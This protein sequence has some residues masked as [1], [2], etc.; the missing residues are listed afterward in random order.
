MRHL[1]KFGHSMTAIT[2]LGS[3]VVLWVFHQQLADPEAALEVYVAERLIMERLAT[4]VTLPSLVLSLLFGLFSMAAVE[5]FHNAPWAWAKLVTT[6]IMLEGSLLGIQSPIKREAALAG[7][8][9]TEPDLISQLAQQLGSEQWS[10]VVIAV[11]A[12]ANVALGVW[13][14]RFRSKL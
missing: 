4:T 2:F 12:A 5:G 9:L 8:A 6:V 3:V 1:L 10:L 7:R 14:P 11:V 13:R